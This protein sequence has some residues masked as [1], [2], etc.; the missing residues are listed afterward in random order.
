MYVE[1]YGKQKWLVLLGI[2]LVS[3]SLDLAADD[4]V[5]SQ[6]E[7]E[8]IVVWGTRDPLSGSGD[9]PSNR[10]RSKD[11]VSINATTTED[12]VKYEP[13]I[14]IRKRFIGDAN[15]TMGI[16]GANMFQTARSMVFADGVP[17]HYFLQTR[18]SGSPRWSLVSADEIAEIE[19]SY[20]PFS[21][22]YSGNSMGGVIN[23]ETAIPDKRK[24]HAE[25]STFQQDF[26]S[27]GYSDDH[28]GYKGFLS[29][30]DKIGNF[31]IYT[32][33]N[34]LENEGHPQSFYFSKHKAVPEG[35]STVAVTGGTLDVNEYGDPAL[36][37]GNA[38]PSDV[39]ADQFKVK[40]GYESNE[41]LT[42]VNLAYE[43]RE[44]EGNSVQN[45]LRDANDNPVWTG[46]VS[47]NGHHFEVEGDD[48]QHDRSDR[49]SLLI[50]GRTRGPVSDNWFI[51]L[52]ASHFEILSDKTYS[53]NVN[54]LDPVFVPGYTLSK[55]FGDTGWSTVDIKL[56]RDDLMNISGLGLLAGYHYESYELEIENASGGKSQT[57]AMYLQ[58][59]YQV[60]DLFRVGLGGRFEKWESNDGFYINRGVFQALRDRSE[61]H[62]S[63]KFSLSFEPLEWHFTYSFGKAYRFP[64][65]EELFQNE[66]TARSRSVA[67]ASLNPEKGL[68]H[69]VEIGHSLGNGS[70]SLNL[71]RETIEDVI[72]SQ[73]GIVGGTSLR[74]FLPVTEVIT[75]GFDL[76]VQQYDLF[77]ANV[78]L[79]FNLNYLDAEIT[80]NDPNPM[81]EGN[82]FPRMPKWRA[83]V[84]A[85]WHAS[86]R[87]DIG[88]GIRFAS[89][90]FGD[91]DNRDRADNVF[92]AH[93]DYLF[94][95]LKSSYKMS[96]N[97]KVSL[98]IDNVTD[99][100]AYVHH[101]WPGRTIYME[102]AL[103][104]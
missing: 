99:K 86:D 12:L 101:P 35:I 22:E 16:R 81:L 91:L 50:G 48:F 72:F 68:H 13:G 79:R 21:S 60:N 90:S 94:I 14:I 19:V 5:I 30:A 10:I 29:Y 23:I 49:R 25:I 51:E 61:S 58:S 92:G 75:N 47:A 9:H 45:Y 65:V 103:D 84:L 56:S 53:T 34:H 52:G 88:L 85:T 44:S 74:T 63:P 64:I 3:I 66:R 80:R 73:T 4:G 32:S 43:D 77:S 7:M 39:S 40:L 70:V 2:S 15:G 71:F 93:D 76:T 83:N 24:V 8:E 31:S 17:L 18:W 26:S 37:Y 59:R 62:F 104:Y 27:L 89:D 57:H 82:E 11:L 98:G 95:N 96:D 87:W 33:L 38:G 97:V 46:W 100:I 28:L 41:W 78:D 1:N 36:Y 6:S 67:N 42:I 54:P 20:G 102:L 55:Q 69:N